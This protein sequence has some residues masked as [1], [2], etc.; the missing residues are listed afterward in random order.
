MFETSNSGQE[1]LAHY[2]TTN[3]GIIDYLVSGTAYN[4]HI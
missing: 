3:G 2:D 4:G 1:L